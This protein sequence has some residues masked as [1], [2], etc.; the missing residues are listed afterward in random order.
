M[1]ISQQLK[2]GKQ[3]HNEPNLSE[4]TRQREAGDG[5]KMRTTFLKNLSYPC[6]GLKL[7]THENLLINILTKCSLLLYYVVTDSSTR[8]GLL[9]ILAV[10]RLVLIAPVSG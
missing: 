4:V 8:L 7:M 3:L 6:I 1:N 10:I 2:L 5:Q 9:P